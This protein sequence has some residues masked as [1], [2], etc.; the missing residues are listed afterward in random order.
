MK[1]HST[2]GLN[3]QMDSTSDILYGE[4]YFEVQLKG[5]FADSKTFYDCIPKIS[6]RHILTNYQQ[7][8]SSSDL[9][10]SKFVEE[11]FHI[12]GRSDKSF[13]MKPNESIVDDLNAMWDVLTRENHETIEGSSLIA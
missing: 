5:V 3:Q 1:D 9:N 8:K 12:P 11:Y 4:L 13:P 2:F 10:L 6:P 7:R